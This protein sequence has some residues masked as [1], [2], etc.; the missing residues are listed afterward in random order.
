MVPFKFAKKE[1][2][3][4]ID[5]RNPNWRILVVDD[6]PEVHAAARLALKNLQFSGPRRRTPE[7]V[8]RRPGAYRAGNR[9]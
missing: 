8:Q 2:P 3:R 7:R 1:P 4:Q 6:D 5:A 9:G